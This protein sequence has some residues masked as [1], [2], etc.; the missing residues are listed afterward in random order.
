MLSSI[1]GLYVF[2]KDES[3]KKRWV[4]DL[5]MSVLQGM[6]KSAKIGAQVHNDKCVEKGVQLMSEHM[7]E[8]K[9]ESFVLCKTTPKDC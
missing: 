2:G 4:V 7:T 1:I 6:C 5:H 9:Q 3:Q 8:N